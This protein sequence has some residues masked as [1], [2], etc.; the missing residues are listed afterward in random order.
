MRISEF[1]EESYQVASTSD[2]FDLL[3]R[4]AAERGFD[5]LAYGTLKGGLSS[6]SGE[7]RAPALALNYPNDW[8][9]H[10]FDHGYQTADP[11]IRYT[12]VM[13]AT[14][15]WAALRQRFDLDEVESRIMDE[16]E[17]AGLR[18]G[19]SV[20]LHGPWG[21]VNVVSFASTTRVPDVA[22]ELGPL[23]AIAT[24]FSVVHA[25]L[26]DERS[27]SSS[28]LQFSE[29]E[30]E[31]L[32]WAAHGKSSWEIGLILGVSE[33][34]VNFHLRKALRKLGTGNRVVAVVKA[35]RYGVIH[36]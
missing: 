34:T 14:Y 25:D 12:P 29:R 1:I 5:R 3:V 23:Q 8:I 24:Q 32:S 7:D 20:P 11:V 30:R 10:Y 13:S 26:T 21:A 9:E 35:I 6:R 18:S 17:E 15:P 36:V 19:V 16:A 28:P 2:L 4:A 33:F 27:I 31:C 22:R